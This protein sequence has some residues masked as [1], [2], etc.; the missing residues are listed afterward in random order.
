MLLFPRKVKHRKWQTGRRN[1]SKP[2]VETRGLRIS[3][4]AYGLK[5]E[6][7]GRIRGNQ[8]EAA[9]KTIVKALGKTG[10]VWIR[11]FTDRPFT[12]KGAEVGMG[13]GKGDPAGYCVEVKPGRVIFEIDGITEGV[14]KEAFRKAGAKLPVKTKMV[15]RT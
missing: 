14:A 15:A 2:A 10:K 11:V 4:G 6:T 1:L 13:A 9:R 5:T 12:Q 3:F 7:L 8:L